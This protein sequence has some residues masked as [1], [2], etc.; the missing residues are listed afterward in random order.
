MFAASLYLRLA[1]NEGSRYLFD[2]ALACAVI[3][4]V[5]NVVISGFYFV[6]QTDITVIG[7]VIRNYEKVN[8]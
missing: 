3:I 6:I 8:K 1:S 7:I 5:L 2:I 4:V